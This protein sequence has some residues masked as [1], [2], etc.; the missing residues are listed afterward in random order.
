EFY[1]DTLF[2]TS[3]YQS[4]YLEGRSAGALTVIASA[5]EVDATV[6]A[7]TVSGPYQRTANT[8]PASGALTIGTSDGLIVPASVVIAPSV[9]PPDLP[10]ATAALPAPWQQT[11]YLPADLL[12]KAGYGSITINAGGGVT[13][14]V[15]K[16]VSPAISVV[17]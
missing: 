4:A 7:T 9:T 3:R 13:D 2:P 6:I 8:L 15:S 14:P 1:T 12:D 16:A 11:V 17:G 10:S 5:A